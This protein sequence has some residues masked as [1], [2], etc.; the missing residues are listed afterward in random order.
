VPYLAFFIPLILDI[1]YA[2]NSKQEAGVKFGSNE[3]WASVAL[4]PLIVFVVLIGTAIVA[5]RLL[6]WLVTAK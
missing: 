2:K 4:F 6:A 3:E 5:F 1:I